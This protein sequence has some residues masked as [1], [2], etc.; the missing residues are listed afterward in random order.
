MYL[1]V[2]I[3]AYNEAK[4]ISKTLDLINDYLSKQNYDSEILV[5]DDGS[6]DGTVGIV[7]EYQHRIKNLKIL[8]NE[9]NHGKGWVVRHG[10]LEALGEYRLFTDADNS[11]SIEQI[12]NFWPYIKQ[13]YDVVVGSIEVAGARINEHAQ[14]YRR[15]LGHFSK[16]LIRVIAGLWFI[17]DTQRGFKLFS[18][19]AVSAIFSR[20]VIDRFGFD[21]EALALAK[22]FRYKI[23]ELP[24]IWNNAGESKVGL[25]SYIATFNDLLRIRFNFWLGRYK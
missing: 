13:G 11:T 2:I 12:E 18:A 16:Y 22:N 7:K 5:V 9:K 25:M 14:W 1:S 4:R 15:M 8:E 19:K 23:K 24:V 6:K 20:T 21:I 3:P 17:H 10:M